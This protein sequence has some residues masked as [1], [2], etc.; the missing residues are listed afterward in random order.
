M[1]NR[2]VEGLCLIFLLLALNVTASGADEMDWPRT[3]AAGDAEVTIYQPQ[4]DSL[5]G[6][7]LSARVVVGVTPS[8]ATEPILGTAWIQARM[9]TDRDHRTAA[10]RPSM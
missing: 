4:P 2:L 8:G 7:T 10:L 3:V 5:K 9:S 6:D 1:R